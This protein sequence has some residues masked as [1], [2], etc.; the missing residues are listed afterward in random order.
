[1]SLSRALSK[2]KTKHFIATVM[3]NELFAKN[4]K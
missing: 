2:E 3:N 1:M 4:E